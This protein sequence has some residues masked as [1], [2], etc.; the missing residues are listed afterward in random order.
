M[1][2][3]RLHAYAKR[4]GK[5]RVTEREC[6]INAGQMS[7]DVYAR[8]YNST[9]PALAV[10][11][12]IVLIVKID[13]PPFRRPIGRVS[14]CLVSA[15]ADPVLIHHDHRQQTADPKQLATGITLLT[16]GYRVCSSMCDSGKSSYEQH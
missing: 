2:A 13:Q 9:L 6:Q 5:R 1:R 12:R 15:F 7:T 16:E 4:R 14:L 8:C 3:W 10:V 11:A